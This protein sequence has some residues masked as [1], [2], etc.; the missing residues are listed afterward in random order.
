MHLAHEN[1]LLTKVN[2]NFIHLTVLL[3]WY[4]SVQNILSS[5]LLSMHVRIKYTKL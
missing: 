4:H 1:V 2:F 5:C 3:A